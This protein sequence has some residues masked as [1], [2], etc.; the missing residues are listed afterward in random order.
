V[1]INTFKYRYTANKYRSS[2]LRTPSA[3][4]KLQKYLKAENLD[5]LLEKS[6]KIL[7]EKLKE[8]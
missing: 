5:Q 3:K 2:I 8:F 6:T 1:Q 4:N 7:N